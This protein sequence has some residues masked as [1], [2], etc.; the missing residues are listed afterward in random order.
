MT[1]NTRQQ[2]IVLLYAL[3][4]SWSVIR[5][6]SDFSA[7]ILSS[8]PQEKKK[9]TSESVVFPKSQVRYG[10]SPPCSDTAI[11]KPLARDVKQSLSKEGR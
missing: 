4:S 2:K 9:T 10:S 7:A 8:F 11:L 5:L 1:I 6:G 3:L